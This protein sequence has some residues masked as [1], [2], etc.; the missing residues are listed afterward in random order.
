MI[1]IDRCFGRQQCVWVW[2]CGVASS[3]A[4]AFGRHL[5]RLSRGSCGND[6]TAIN[7]PIASSLS[8]ADTIYTWTC[9]G[10]GAIVPSVGACIHA[11]AKSMVAAQCI[12]SATISLALYRREIVSATDNV[13]IDIGI[14]Q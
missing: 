11:N 7:I 12:C 10:F 3:T 1:N 5:F 13:D 2:G 9:F 8:R 6:T 14:L 4:F